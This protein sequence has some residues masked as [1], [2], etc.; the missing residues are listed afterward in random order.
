MNFKIKFK[1]EL[2]RNWELG[3]CPF[4]QKCTFAHGPNELRQKTHVAVNYKTKKCRQFFQKGFCS[5]GQ[6]CQF[7][8]VENAD[9]RSTSPSPS[10]AECSFEERRRLPVFLSLERSA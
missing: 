4:G 2:C 10:T 6:R 5:Y 7:L 1:T 8:H 3:Q 9:S